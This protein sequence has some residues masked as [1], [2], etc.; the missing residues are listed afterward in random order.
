MKN[1]YKFEDLLIYILLIKYL[2]IQL[3]LLKALIHLYHKEN[4]IHQIVLLL[5]PLLSRKIHY[6]PQQIVFLYYQFIIFK[7]SIGNRPLSKARLLK[8]FK[9]FSILFLSSISFLLF[10]FES[11]S[12]TLLWD[13]K[14]SDWFSVFKEIFFSISL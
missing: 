1:I 4:I 3:L 6:F 12:F 9:Y 14:I 11:F 5:N 8:L 13:F 7:Y 10:C 2:L